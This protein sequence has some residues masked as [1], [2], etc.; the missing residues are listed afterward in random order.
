VVGAPVGI[1]L[2]LL[3][4]LG[5][6]FA[7]VPA[8]AALG[9]VMLR[10]RGGILGAFVVGALVWRLGIWLIPVVGLLLYTAALMSGSG[11][12]VLAGWR[13]RRAM[14]AAAP[15]LVPKTMRGDEVAAPDDW[16]PPLAPVAATAEESGADDPT[17]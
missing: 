8:V 5:L 17:G 4:V 9:D 7:P 13:Q 16:E 2:I 6:V 3:W 10:G 11:G 14:L 1:L 15:P 12:I